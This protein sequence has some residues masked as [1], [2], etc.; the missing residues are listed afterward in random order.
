MC[1]GEIVPVQVLAAEPDAYWIWD[2]T[3]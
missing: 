2:E 1:Q 3:E